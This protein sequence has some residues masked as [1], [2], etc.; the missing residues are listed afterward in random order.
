MTTHDDTTLEQLGQ[1]RRETLAVAPEWEAYARG[2]L[3]EDETR[4]R[5]LAAGDEAA[6]VERGLAL[7]RP[8]A[9]HELERLRVASQRVL[10]E[11]RVRDSGRAR[12]IAAATVLAA[13]AAL[14]FIIIRPSR[15]TEPQLAALADELPTYEL[16]LRGK[17]EQVR[18]TPSDEPLALAPETSFEWTFTP[19]R[20]VHAPL[21]GEILAFPEQGPGRVLALPIELSPTGSLHVETLGSQLQLEPGDWTI[22]IAVG[23]AELDDRD[24]L[25]LLDPRHDERPNSVWRSTAFRVAVLE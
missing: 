25:E 15:D 22:V 10:D 23:W 20:D 2:E 5:R 4:R 13:A 3:S 12:T 21:Q 6:T 9:A 14:L 16:E 8:L 18:G 24:L 19:I 7:Y 1:R 17:V 11:R